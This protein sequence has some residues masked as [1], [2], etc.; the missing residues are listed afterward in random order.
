MNLHLETTHPMHLNFPESPWPKSYLSCVHSPLQLLWDKLQWSYFR[1]SAD[2]C[3]A[4]LEGSEL[5]VQWVTLCCGGF[6]SNRYIG[7]AAT[8]QQTMNAPLNTAL[9]PGSSTALWNWSK[10]FQELTISYCQMLWSLHPDASC[11]FTFCLQSHS[12]GDPSSWHQG[13]R[14]FSHL[15]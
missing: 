1:L 10:Q 6:I 7:N 9:A 11:T 14:L 13:H 3:I 8:L 12:L 5:E 4:V 15:H 2:Y